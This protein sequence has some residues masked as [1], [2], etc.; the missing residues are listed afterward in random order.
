M[1]EWS[2]EQSKAAELHELGPAA[3]TVLYGAARR[4]A[5]ADTPAAIF[6]SMLDAACSIGG[7]AAVLYLPAPGNIETDLVRAAQSGTGW[8][9]PA[10]THT[11]MPWREVFAR[12]GS[13]GAELAELGPR[14]ALFALTGEREPH[15][16]LAA[17]WPEDE[18]APPGGM[19]AL[20]ALAHDAGY[21]LDRLRML[22]GAARGD[23]GVQ[24]L[25]AAVNAVTDVGLLYSTLVEPML[26]AMLGQILA[27]LPLGGGA[28]YLTSEPSEQVELVAWARGSEEAHGPDPAIL[29]EGAAAIYALAQA[30]ETARL[31]YP[32]SIIEARQQAGDP[33]Q[34]L[35]AALQQLGAGN[36]VSLPLLA[37]GWLS[38][39]LQVI[40]APGRAIT[41]RQIQTLRVVARQAA[42]AIENARLVAQTRADQERARAVVEATNDAILMLDEHRRPMIVNRRA[43]FFF[44]LTERDLLGKSFEQLAAL[45]TRIVEEG[46]GF[47]NWLVRLL[48][49]QNERAVAEFRVLSPEPRLLQ[50]YSAPVLDPHNRYLG[51]LLVFR[52]VTREREVERMKS[53][54]VSIV[55]H[56]LRTPLTSI[57]GALQLILGQPELG[58]PGMGAGLS[59]QGRELLTISRSNTERLIRLINDILDIAK[60]EQGRIELRRE[61]LAPEDLCRSAAAEMSALANSRGIAVELQLRPLLPP[62][63]AD[64]DRSVQ[65]L[66]N[67]LSNA[68][69][70]SQPGQRVALSA[71]HEGSTICFTVQDWGR[72]I[73]PEHQ[74]AL[75]QRFQQIDSSATRDVG[76]TGLG[77]AI[78]KALVEEMGGRMWLDS[79]LGQGSSFSFTLPV[80]PGGDEQ[81]EKPER[82]ILV[83]D[84]DPHVRPV[85]VRLLQRHGLRVSSAHDGYGALAAVEAEVPDVVLLDIKM[86]GLDG[87]E[88]LRRLKS[89]PETAAVPIVILTANDLS[90]STRAHGLQLGARAYLEKPITYERLVNTVYAVMEP[91]GESR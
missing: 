54:F 79:E 1:W 75:F 60:I 89:R 55:S 51:R 17:H 66:V 65:V 53:D 3:L 90:D 24:G 47:N 25:L 62:V 45:F 48:G 61:V 5:R 56:E 33:S 41:P 64:R 38:G 86:P 10:R 20:R 34:A 80:A 37:G 16:L 2:D 72:G 88:V 44:G 15:G 81:S 67:L 36:L 7:C 73:A 50:C 49:S 83:V 52:D 26:N 28:I 21:A 30:R 58:K 91:D 85:L 23:D 27:V 77:L 76:G 43:R 87:F 78:S 57:Q 35:S 46:E 8:E 63:L 39:V 69:K 32:A 12:G 11:Q 70:F 13:P 42:A 18:A 74:T 84:D 59:P 68:I 9:P 82:H 19:A 31:A 14:V 4:L 6:R 40:A 29:W 22:Q 71:R